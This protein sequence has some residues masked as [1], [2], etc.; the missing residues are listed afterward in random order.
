ME[1]WKAREYSKENKCEV[2]VRDACTSWLSLCRLCAFDI[3][4]CVVHVGPRH[5]AD[6][7]DGFHSAVDR[8]YPAPYTYMAWDFKGRQKEWQ[9][10][11]EKF[12]SHGKRNSPS[13]NDF[14]EFFAY[15]TGSRNLP[16]LRLSR[17]IGYS[18][19]WH[20]SATIRSIEINRLVNCELHHV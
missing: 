8:G 18:N 1:R 16:I 9:E 15:K 6:W 4:L 12:S 5:G 10:K 3:L 14:A 11:M 20:V 19:W 2:K 7:N 13:T 17:E